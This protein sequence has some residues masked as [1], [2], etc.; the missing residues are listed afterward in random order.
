MYVVIR[1]VRLE[2]RNFEIQKSKAKLEIPEFLAFPL[3]AQSS[4]LQV[5]ILEK[6]L[7]RLR[8]V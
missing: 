2:S 3:V 8:M 7:Q 1:K 6:Y 4:D 5:E